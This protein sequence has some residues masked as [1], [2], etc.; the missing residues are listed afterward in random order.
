MLLIYPYTI[1]TA[2][3]LIVTAIVTIWATRIYIHAFYAATFGKIGNRKIRK[4]GRAPYVTIFLPIYN[5]DMVVDR[6][7]RSVTSIDYPNYEIIVAD[8]SIDAMT[9][10]LLKK[11]QKNRNVKIIHRNKRHGFKAGALNNAIMHVNPKSEYFAMFDADYVPEPD[12]IWKM[13]N[14]LLSSDA[15]AVQGYPDQRINA[16][17]NIFT[18]GISVGF[19]PYCLVDAPVREKLNGFIPIFG[20]VFMI[21]RDVLKKVGGFNESSITEDWDLASKLIQRGYRVV[22]DEN[23]HAS[24]ECPDTFHSLVK[25]QMRWGEGITRDTRHNLI[26]VL[27]SKK[28]NLLKKFD[29]VF[30]GFGSLNCIFGSVSYIIVLSVLLIGLGLVHGPQ[31]DKG[32]VLWFGQAGIFALYIAP[33]YIPMALILATLVGLYR[34]NRIG[35]AHWIPYMLFVNTLLVPFIAFA[36]LRGLFFERGSWSRTPKTGEVMKSE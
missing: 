8:D 9:V 12:V 15:A 11:W 30:Y 33:I 10:S 34:E 5:E 29:Y 24:G 16:G 31:I 23:I 26:A 3:W 13:V 19:A 4:T 35:K 14:S 32:L 7:L 20:T 6:L 28:V 18:K 22:Y 1:E 25:Q 21:S 2:I 27:L 36:S 17:K